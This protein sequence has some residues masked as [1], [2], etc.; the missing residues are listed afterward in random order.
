MEQREYLSS[1]LI[2]ILRE[3]TSTGGWFHSSL[4]CSAAQGSCPIKSVLTHGFVVDGKGKAM[5]KS[6]G[7]VIYATETMIRKMGQR[8]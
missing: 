3:V 2:F 1:P 7:N 4:L 6:A 5:H 8:Y